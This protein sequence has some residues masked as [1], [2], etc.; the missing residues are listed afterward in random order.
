ME[1]L[2]DLRTCKT[3]DI[4][5]SRHGAKLEYVAPTPWKHV[6]YLE[7]VV[8]HVEYPDGTPVIADSY[9]SRTTSG[10]ILED[11]TDRCMQH[12]DI[13]QIIHI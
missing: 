10:F 9:G 4:L 3:G 8:R 13:V 11:V 1:Q 12:L 2:V 5:I 6:T 7:H